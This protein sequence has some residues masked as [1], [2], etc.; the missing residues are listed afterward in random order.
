MSQSMQVTQDQSPSVKAEQLAATYHLGMPQQ[1]YG[2]HPKH[3]RVHASTLRRVGRTFLPYW[4]HCALVV[5]ALIVMT[6]LNSVTRWSA[7]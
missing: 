7:G 2:G 5:V 1:E 3:Q 6:V 4:R